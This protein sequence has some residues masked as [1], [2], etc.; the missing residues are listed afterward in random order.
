MDAFINKRYKVVPQIFLQLNSRFMSSRD[1]FWFLAGVLVSGA[2]T[3]LLLRVWSRER[4][5]VRRAVPAFAL[6]IAAAL[7]LIGVALGIYF[8]LGS[9]ASIASAHTNA[10]QAASV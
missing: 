9:P 5:A 7:G 1:W 4:P 6:P 2:S 8:L 3:V 10:T